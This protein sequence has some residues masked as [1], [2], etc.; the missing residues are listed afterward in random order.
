MKIY[1][2]LLLFISCSKEK[3]KTTKYLNISV[4]YEYLKSNMTASDFEK[5]D[6]SKVI[7]SRLQDDGYLLSI[8]DKTNSSNVLYFAAANNQIYQSLVE[9]KI[10][11]RLSNS[12]KLII[13]TLDGNIKN[14]ILLL[15]GRVTKNKTQ[16]MLK[17]YQVS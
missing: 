17:C 9:Y 16:I 13:K 7:F 6:W 5:Y 10:I 11:D 14:E 15:N 12:G 4:G 8:K 2:V 1:T 3:L